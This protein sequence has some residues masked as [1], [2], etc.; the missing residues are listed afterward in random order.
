MEARSQ[1]RGG[2]KINWIEWLIQW[3]LGFSQFLAGIIAGT[4]ITGVFTWKVI[5][6]KASK[7][8]TQNKDIQNLI[9]LLKTLSE[10]AE[11]VKRL[12]KEIL[13]NQQRTH[14]K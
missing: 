8:I 2:L 14:R 4:I 12:L 7:A 3:I 5:V 6:P 11:D 1:T 9:S 10:H 13:E